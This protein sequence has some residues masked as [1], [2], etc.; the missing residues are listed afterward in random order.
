MPKK[1]CEYCGANMNADCHAHAQY[2]PLSCEYKK[3]E[4]PPINGSLPVGDGLSIMLLL[5]IIYIAIK[6]KN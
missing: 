3:P 5:S 1:T 2:C 4:N 6:L